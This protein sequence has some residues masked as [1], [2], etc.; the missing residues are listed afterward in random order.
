M[1]YYILGFSLIIISLFGCQLFGPEDPSPT[2]VPT[3]IPLSS[4]TIEPLGTS[5]YLSD[6]SISKGAI[7]PEFN[8]EITDYLILLDYMVTL[9]RLQY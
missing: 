8:R 9:F 7:S 2:P 3:S 6:I 5:S 1:K 4:P